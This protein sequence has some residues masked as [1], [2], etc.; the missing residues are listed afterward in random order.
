ME[1]NLESITTSI[2]IVGTYTLIEPKE[3]ENGLGLFLLEDGSVRW[4]VV[5][6]NKEV[7]Q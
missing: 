3:D 6:L 7:N 2:K 1:P 5:T 4:S